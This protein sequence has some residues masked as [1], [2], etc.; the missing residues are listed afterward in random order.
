MN[1]RYPAE[2]CMSID[3]SEGGLFL[4]SSLNHYYVGMEVYLTRDAAGSPAKPEE[5]GSVVRAIKTPDGKC[6]VAVRIIPEA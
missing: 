2:T 1:T 6:R 3:V 4:E 5:H